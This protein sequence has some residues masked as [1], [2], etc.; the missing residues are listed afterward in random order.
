MVAKITFPKR[1]KA[2][3]TY[4]EKKVQKEVATCIGSH[5]YL[6]ALEQM[7]F[8]HKLSGLENRNSLN[9]RALSNTMH[10]SLNFHPS[11]KLSKALLLQIASSYMEKIGFS[12]Q[13][14]L[15]YEHFD[16]GHPHLHIVSTLIREDGSRIPTHNIGRNASEK[17]RTELE[18]KFHLVRAGK[19][20]KYSE[21]TVKAFELRKLPYGK[22]ETKKHIAAVVGHVMRTYHFSSLAGFNAILAQYQ[23]QADR[24]KQ[25]SRMYQHKGL[26]Y[27]MLDERGEKVGVPI[28]ASSLPSQPTL[29]NLEKKFQLDSVKSEK[30]RNDL[31]HKVENV[32]MQKPSVLKELIDLLSIKKVYTVLRRSREGKIYGI[33]FVDNENKCVFNGSDLDRNLSADSIQKRL[34]N[35]TTQPKGARANDNTVMQSHRSQSF[36]F[37]EQTQKQ[38][39]VPGSMDPLVSPTCHTEPIPFQLRKKKK[40]KKKINF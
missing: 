23:I 11:E 24:G 17:A 13:P 14:Y 4:N 2:T 16:A 22:T 21:M 32:L 28:K 3:L 19:M 38:F 8:L 40:K 25:T 34:Q 9:T 6:R 30:L 20:G 26:A 39:I 10:A 1:V 27:R 35:Q 37:E 7:N 12:G 5:G 29:S 33:T 18:E 36:L 31:R 15:V